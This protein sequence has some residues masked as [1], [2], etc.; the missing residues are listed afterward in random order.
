MAG[1]RRLRL[2][3]LLRAGTD[4]VEIGRLCPATMAATASDGAGMM[5]MSGDVARGSVCA[6]D[7]V[8]T[9]IEDLQFTQGDGP[10]VDAHRGG[11]PVLE[12]DLA[13]QPRWPA[14][15]G[16]VVDAGVCAIFGFPLHVDAVRLGAL[17]VYRTRPGP[18]TADEH[19]DALVMADIAT[20]AVLMVQAG[21][22]PGHLAAE[23][24]DS[25]DLHYAVHQA[26]GM[27]AAQL[28]VSVGQALIRLRGHAFGNDRSLH[29]VAD[30]VV[31]RRLHF[32]DPDGEATVVAR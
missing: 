13:H 10:C 16:P 5:L 2:L 28:E 7:D 26:S 9:L 8:S 12:P 19:A 6:T 22:E 15:T 20:R 1:P 25:L 17:H 18:L 27:V 30:D 32:R 21:A 23:L 4:D 11:R 14:F 24:E 3:A 29:Q 31:D